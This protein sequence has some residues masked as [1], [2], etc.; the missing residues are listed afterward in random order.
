[1]P[2]SPTKDMTGPILSRTRLLPFLVRFW[3][4][5]MTRAAKW[6]FYPCLAIASY[7]SLSL[8][9]QAYVAF[10]YC[11]A[12]WGVAFVALVIFRPKLTLRAFQ[13][14]RVC[15]GETFEVGLE[16]ARPRG[17]LGTDLTVIAHRLPV[18]VDAVEEVGVPLPDLRGA[19][20]VRATLRLVAAKRGTYVLRGYR[21]ESD[22]PLGLL[23]AVQAF[24]EERPLLVYPSFQRLSRLDLPSSRKHQP[25]GVALASIVGESTEF[26]GDRDYREGDNV[27]DIDWR[28]T[29]RLQRLIVREYREEY[30]HRVAV[31]LDTH[32]PKGSSRAR[33]D[34]FEKA[35]SLCAAIGDAL[36]REEY[37]VDIFA[38]GPML[39]HLAAGRS[40]AYLDQILDILACVEESRD[41]PLWAIQPE[42]AE[43]LGRI[44]SAVCVFV[45]WDARRMEFLEDLRRKGVSV[46]AV[47]VRTG[48]TTMPAD[49]PGLQLFE[50]ADVAAGVGEL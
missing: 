26:V 33:G 29:G 18:G 13:P 23:N 41:E 1:M 20:P 19:H 49:A 3:I 35:V 28:A 50:A 36:A 14:A 37:I 44:S 30:F 6:F 15:A 21:V 39:Y 31:V 5:R 10:S 25:G 48:A 32:V 47:I 24:E 45:D 17:G 9:Y 16:V 38:A 27:R 2:L 40:L 4:I 7:A 46:K 43:Y 22:F 12:L 11:A 34:D 42:L 8:N